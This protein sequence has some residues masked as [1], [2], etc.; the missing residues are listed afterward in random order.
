MSQVKLV[1]EGGYFTGSNTIM[2]SLVMEFQ[3][4]TWKL[5]CVYFYLKLNVQRIIL[6]QYFLCWTL[7]E[8][9]DNEELVGNCLDISPGSEF[10]YPLLIASYCTA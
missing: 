10:S 3:I 8:G 7:A 9:K 2:W 4:I 5:K 1:L 6:P